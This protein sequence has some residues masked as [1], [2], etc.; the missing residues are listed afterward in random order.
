MRLDL[1]DFYYTDS[2]YEGLKSAR[3]TGLSK[4]LITWLNNN[5]ITCKHE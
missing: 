3:R 5:E 1:D 4:F 2:E